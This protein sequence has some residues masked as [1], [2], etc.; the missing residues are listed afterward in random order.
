MNGSTNNK[1]SIFNK[2]QTEW[3]IVLCGTA[4]FI[5]FVCARAVA[6][7]GMV[8]L[9]VLAL[10]STN[11]KTVFSNYF[12]RS[13]LWVLSIF[14]W[15]VFISGLWSDDKTN[16]LNWV[17]IKIPYIALPLAF[18][19]FSRLSEKKFIAILYAFI[20]TLNISAAIILVFCPS[21]NILEQYE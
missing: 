5:G 2:T 9:I 14:F 18:A 6:S 11:P 15:V 16:W 21:V 8:A 7:I 17:R 3:L 20:L 10:L 19:A 1:Y 13:E 4:V 12:K